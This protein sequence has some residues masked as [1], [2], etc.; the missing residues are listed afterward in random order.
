LG[1]LDGVCGENAIKRSR[2]IWHLIYYNQI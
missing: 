1:V 2:S